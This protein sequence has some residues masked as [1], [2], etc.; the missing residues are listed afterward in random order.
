MFEK[1]L[2]FFPGISVVSQPGPYDGGTDGDRIGELLRFVP[3]LR[4]IQ[5]PEC[6]VA[7]AVE[8]AGNLVLRLVCP[9][10]RMKFLKYNRGYNRIDAALARPDAPD[11]I[12]SSIYELGPVKGVLEK[13]EPGLKV[14]KSGRTTGITRG[15]IVGTG[16]TV[17]VEV[18]D[19]E[20]G[21]FEDQVVSDMK[22]R[23]GDSGSL[24]LDEQ[25]RAVGLL[26]AGSDTVCV[27]NP[28]VEVL[29]RLNVVF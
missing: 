11:L 21:W 22:C 29:N 5:E 13:V 14:Q 2:S 18:S 23:G 7:A 24:V 26:F 8:R 25:M 27:F 3:L 20:I 6:A 1:G 15:E 19:G 9:R 4:E 28:I 17:K 12:E 16:V 10:Y